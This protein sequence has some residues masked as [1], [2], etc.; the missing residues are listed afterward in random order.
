MTDFIALL[1]VIVHALERATLIIFS[2]CATRVLPGARSPMRYLPVFF[3]IFA[4]VAANPLPKRTQYN[5]QYAKQLLNL[6]AGA[7]SLT[8][9]VCVNRFVFV[10]SETKRKSFPSS[11]LG[12]S[13]LSSSLLT[14]GRYRKRINGNSTRRAYNAVTHTAAAAPTT[15]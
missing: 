1:T 14:L 13:H 9:E 4:C 8:P 2:R 3:C 10:R 5:E 11:M 7:Y 12:V 15:S 6:A